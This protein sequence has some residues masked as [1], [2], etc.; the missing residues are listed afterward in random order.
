[1]GLQTEG[2]LCDSTCRKRSLSR[3]K[4]FEPFGEQGKGKQPCPF[5]LSATRLRIVLTATR[6]WAATSSITKYFSIYLSFALPG[7][8]TTLCGILISFTVISGIT[9]FFVGNQQRLL[10]VRD[11]IDGRKRNGDLLPHTVEVR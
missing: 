2:G 3:H 8:G 1:M 5:R 9:L 7:L 4:S 10:I 11:M 6:I